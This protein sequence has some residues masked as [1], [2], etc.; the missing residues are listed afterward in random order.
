M[1]L[2]ANNFLIQIIGLSKSYRGHGLERELASMGLSYISKVGIEISN[3]DFENEVF[4]SEFISKQILKRNITRG[5]IGCAL[6][7]EYAYK[8]L[9]DSDKNFSL[10]FEDDV[11]LQSKIDFNLIKNCLESESPR[12]VL[13]GYNDEFSIPKTCYENV[14]AGCVDLLVPSTGAFAYA[15]NRVAA[16]I[17]INKEAKLRTVAD[18]PLNASHKVK[19]TILIPKVAE[20]NNSGMKSVIDE[21]SVRT[22]HKKFPFSN[23]I[24]KAFVVCFNLVYLKIFKNLKVT[25][26][27][28]FY[29]SFIKDTLYKFA[30]RRRR[31]LLFKF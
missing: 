24:S 30:F 8:R 18:W 19:F 16:K 13:L 25:F 2:S 1:T 26:F 6:A 20:I 27:E 22:F 5:E 10:I 7:H 9:L 29:T 14:H 12:I 4:H 15:I 11:K 17:L 23:S 3:E 21:I 28:I 31:K